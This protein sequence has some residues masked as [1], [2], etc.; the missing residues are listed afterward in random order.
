M[1]SEEPDSGFSQWLPATKQLKQFMTSPGKTSLLHRQVVT[2]GMSAAEKPI[3]A[4][5]ETSA[6]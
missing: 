4:D 3:S 1:T 5:S 6:R 2:P